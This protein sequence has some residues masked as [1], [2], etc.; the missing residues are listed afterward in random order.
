VQ[1][2]LSTRTRSNRWRSA[3]SEQD[4]PESKPE[5]DTPSTQ[6][7]SQTQPKLESERPV[8]LKKKPTLPPR[9]QPPSEST[10]LASLLAYSGVVGSVAVVLATVLHLDPFGSF[11]LDQD[12]I[13]RGILMATPV[14]A[15]TAFI[16]LPDWSAWSLPPMDD[17]LNSTAPNFVGSKEDAERAAREAKSK[18]S[19]DI[20]TS[21]SAVRTSAPTSEATTNTADASQAAPAAETDE[22]WLNRS[23]VA[24][25]DS[26]SSPASTSSS[27]D[28]QAAGASSRP[29]RSR[30]EM[31]GPI[32]GAGA[33]A[34]PWRPQEGKKLTGPAKAVATFK[35]ALHL[36]QGYYIGNNPSKVRCRCAYMQ[37]GC[38]LL[39]QLVMTWAVMMGASACTHV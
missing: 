36:A 28:P 33:P 10:I 18:Q 34:M 20:L 27:S 7:T 24:A 21:S 16:M 4:A 25:S 22:P 1:T 35:D 39:A 11:H 26:S 14:Y 37:A 30:F 19:P 15:L 9:W 6:D 13:T 23:A 8:R 32:A 2:L 5:A 17:M 12:D 38:G 29:R 31:D 3:A